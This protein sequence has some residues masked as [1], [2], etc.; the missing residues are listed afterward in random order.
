MKLRLVQPAA[1]QSA[2]ANKETH[3]QAFHTR[4]P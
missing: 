2:F 1:R 3:F 4:P